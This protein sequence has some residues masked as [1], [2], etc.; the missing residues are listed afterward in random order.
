MFVCQPVEWEREKGKLSVV[1]DDV[2]ATIKYPLDEKRGQLVLYLPTVFFFLLIFGGLHHILFVLFYFL[3]LLRRPISIRQWVWLHRLLPRKR[4]MCVYVCV[5]HYLHDPSV[6]MPIGKPLPTSR[7]GRDRKEPG[8][9]YAYNISV[10]CYVRI[11][12]CPASLDTGHPPL[13]SHLLEYYAYVYP[14]P[15][16]T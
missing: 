1:D 9:I 12:L 4:K 16:F 5:R 13:T 14:P 6:L 10:L 7:P 2:S 3:C 15:T 11:A 8:N